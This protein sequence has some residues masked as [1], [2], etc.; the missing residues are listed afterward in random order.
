MSDGLTYSESLTDR[1]ASLFLALFLLH[2]LSTAAATPPPSTR[3]CTAP[4]TRRPQP[5]HAPA[6]ATAADRAPARAGRTRRCRPRPCLAR[7][8]GAAVVRSPCLHELQAPPQVRRRPCL[9]LAAAAAAGRARSCTTPARC[10]QTLG[11][12]LCAPLRSAPRASGGTGVQ[13]GEG[14][15]LNC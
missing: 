10:A 6:A 8:A 5:L 12:S 2:A 7:V 3:P 13:E 1:P 4:S 9:A 14:R 15:E 11:A